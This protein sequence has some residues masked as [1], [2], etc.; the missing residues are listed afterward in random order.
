[1]GNRELEKIARKY[2]VLNALKYGTPDFK[3][4][5]GKV[6]ASFP[7]AKKNIKATVELVKRIVEEISRMPAED[8]KKLAEEL[9]VEEEK[10]AEKKD[11][12]ALPNAEPGKVKTRIAPEPNGYLHIGH[13]ISF[14]LNFMYA[15][16]YSGSVVLKLEDTNPLKESPEFY[17]AILRDL[18]WLGIEFDELYIISEHFEEIEK[19]AERLIRKGMAYVCTCPP[20][21][22]KR[23]RIAMEADPCRAHSKEENLELWERMKTGERF[24]LR[25]MGEPSAANA[26]LRDPVLYRVLDVVHPWT[27]ENHV[28]Y[29]TYD[30]ANAFTDGSLGIT[31]VLRSEEFLQRTELHKRL[32]KALGFKPPTYVHYG[33]FSLEGTP[34][35]KRK[36]RPL[37]ESGLVTGW[38]DPRLATIMA[39]R[40]RGILPE[41]LKEL[42]KSVGLHLG[43]AEFTWELLLGIN[44]KFLD[45][46]A[47]RI[48]AVEDPVSLKYEGPKKTV[49]LPFHPDIDVGYRTLEIKP[50]DE[51]FIERK[52][53]E[54]IK[55][56]EFRLK[57]LCK[58]R[59]ADNVLQCLGEEI[60]KP[61]IHWLPKKMAVEAEVIK[62][63]V[64][65]R[66]EEIDKGSLKIE[67][68]FV[69]KNIYGKR[70][71]HYQFERLYFVRLENYRPLR[72]VKV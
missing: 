2:A 60:V 7:E 38:D 68:V 22:I 63:G 44:R 69:E 11:L 62:A 9:G 53:F 28:I 29:P 26:V 72:F 12:D 47:L 66:G 27:G 56:K 31:H 6:I 1:M 65:M 61:I 15:R 24:V 19:A 58:A 34:V 16:K 46:K 71:L 45:K 36:I 64:L 67:R 10:K 55:S 35:S 5:L 37:V 33:R 57:G 40:R 41:T 30:M 23:R 13:A 49:K 18:K 21:E 17:A 14:L 42:A 48:F 43:K 51:I 32:M 39:L 20:E 3:S 59:I 25:F 8:I 4:T 50:G 70:W 52:D 54:R